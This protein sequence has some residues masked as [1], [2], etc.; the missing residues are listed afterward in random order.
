[1]FTTLKNWNVRAVAAENWDKYPVYVQN[2]PFCRKHR[3]S[4]IPVNNLWMI[5]EKLI[6]FYPQLYNQ[7]ITNR[8]LVP[9]AFY[10]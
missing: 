7:A 3:K 8:A 5:F 10:L 1:M 9:K 2:Y 4:Y 6:C